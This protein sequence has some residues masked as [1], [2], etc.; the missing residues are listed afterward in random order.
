MLWF[1]E[2]ILKKI[3]LL[4]KILEK[5]KN[6]KNWL[7]CWKKLDL[8]KTNT[9]ST[10]GKKI[11]YIAKT[12]IGEFL[13]Q[14]TTMRERDELR[15]F[16][17]KRN[18][19][20]FTNF[21]KFFGFRRNWNRPAQRMRKTKKYKK[22]KLYKKIV[23]LFAHAINYSAEPY[24]MY[25]LQGIRTFLSY[26]K[27]RWQSVAYF[28]KNYFSPNLDRSKI[29]KLSKKAHHSHKSKLITFIAKMELTASTLLLKTRLLASRGL[30]NQFI[31]HGN[32]FINYKKITFP[33][34]SLTIGDTLSIF[35]D[36]TQYYFHRLNDPL[37]TN[38][39]RTGLY[40]KNSGRQSIS[41]LEPDCFFIK[42][43]LGV[44]N[45]KINNINLFGDTP[46]AH[47][48]MYKIIWPDN[49]YGI[50]KKPNKD[51]F[52]S[53]KYSFI[54]TPISNLFIKQRPHID[55][56]YNPII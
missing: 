33:L 12:T 15:K 30:V 55:K 20:R 11:H 42:N 3:K 26:Y 1:K 23:N 52:A 39:L 19:Q 27:M 50:F 14:R 28:L 41:A 38:R 7:S 49:H 51:K 45:K 13:I 4:N 9:I 18:L 36:T 44:L 37:Y 16:F 34:F 5:E 22:F 31:K 10:I 56:I 40:R 2:R 6:S 53:W 29:S 8:K 25:P 46:Y 21:F 17:E 32:V 54:V 48:N 24:D 35:I 43:G 47:S